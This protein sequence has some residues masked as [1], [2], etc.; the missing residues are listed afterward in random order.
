M[1]FFETLFDGA[2]SVESEVMGLRRGAGKV[3]VTDLRGKNLEWQMAVGEGSQRVEGG[4]GVDGVFACC[5][6]VRG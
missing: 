1:L 3:S 4:R 6:L 5:C 2:K